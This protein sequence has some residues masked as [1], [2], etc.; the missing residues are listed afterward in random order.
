M[1]DNEVNRVVFFACLLGIVIFFLMGA[2]L[3]NYGDLR[4]FHL[5]INCFLSQS[6]SFT[7]QGSNNLDQL[8]QQILR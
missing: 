4:I 3:F 2:K 5:N 7:S 6:C 8:S 1:S